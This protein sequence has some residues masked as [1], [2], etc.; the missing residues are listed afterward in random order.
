MRVGSDDNKYGHLY[1]SVDYIAPSVARAMEAA[2]AAE[3][4]VFGKTRINGNNSIQSMTGQSGFESLIQRK[5]RN[6]D[7]YRQ[8]KDRV[9][10]SDKVEISRHSAL[11][12]LSR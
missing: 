6:K 12:T 9:I 5:L 7:L 11:N 8:M 1:Q 10:Y 4:S 2:E 3:A